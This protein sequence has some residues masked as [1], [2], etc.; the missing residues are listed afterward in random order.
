MR[1]DPIN[2]LANL[3][4][5]WKEQSDKEI[6]SKANEAEV[7]AYSLP[8][9]EAKQIALTLLDD[10]LRFR[11]TKSEPTKIEQEKIENF[12]PN[13]KE[14]FTSF[15]SVEMIYG[16]PKIDRKMIGPSSFDKRC[17]IVGEIMD[18]GEAVV[19]PGDERIFELDD[20]D[21]DSEKQQGAPSIYHWF[22]YLAK[23]TESKR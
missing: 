23:L 20:W 11:I 12:A 4:W 19:R 9:S 13:L 21:L 6:K 3:L 15:Q 1:I 16:D 2:W 14:F 10:P 5:K 18:F 17:I 22:V 8:L 7:W